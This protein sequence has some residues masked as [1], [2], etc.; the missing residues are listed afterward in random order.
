MSRRCI[1]ILVVAGLIAGC[2]STANEP[3]TTAMVVVEAFLYAGERVDDIRLTETTPLSDTVAP[4]PINDAQV[5]LEKR[6]ISYPLV[7]TGVDGYYEYPGDDLLV[8]AADTF[9]IEVTHLDGVATGETV[10]PRPPE[11]VTIDRHTLWVPEIGA[12]MPRG[13][14]NPED[15]RLA[16]TW[17]NPDRLLHYVVIESLEEDAEP[18]VPEE[19]QRFARRFRLVTPPTTDDF[20]FIDMRSLQYLGPHVARIYRVN[21]EYARL[22]ENRTQDSRDLNEPP[23]N[24]EG[25]LGVFSAFNSVAVHFEVARESN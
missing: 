12:G 20:H 7:S 18:I 13:G 25:G 10:V 6:G 21:D 3:E 24:I 8:E 9:R 19:F 2:G 4:P 5:V 14:F 17:D 22:Y 1:P 15:S 11:G 16:A 23:T